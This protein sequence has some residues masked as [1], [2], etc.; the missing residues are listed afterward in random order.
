MPSGL[1]AM[2]AR[3]E[4]TRD[5]LRRTREETE[6]TQTT[7]SQYLTFVL[8]AAEETDAKLDSTGEHA[9]MT[10]AQIAVAYG[11]AQKMAQAV[12]AEYKAVLERLAAPE[13]LFDYAGLSLEDF[14][15]SQKNLIEQI[16]GGGFG[17][18]LDYY[19]KAYIDQLLGNAA[20]VSGAAYKQM[21]QSAYIIR[22]FTGA[23]GQAFDFFKFKADIDAA[24]KGIKAELSGSASGAGGYSG[25]YGS[26]SGTL[27]GHGKG[28]GCGASMPSLSILAASGALRWR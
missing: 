11:E 13:N 23:A 12:E 16:G 5:N 2:N 24:L 4:E 9:E 19:A 7:V 15:A 1:R 25:G 10:I 20:A 22:H 21:E 6:K 8:S 17:A 28:G 27:G 18:H 26:S 3:L 14:G